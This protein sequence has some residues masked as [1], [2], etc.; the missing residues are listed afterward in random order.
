MSN[1]GLLAEAPRQPH[2]LAP[3]GWLALVAVVAAQVIGFLISRPDRVMGN[4][5]KIMYVHVP[6]AWVAMI[7]FFLV[8]VASMLYLWRRDLKYDRL[9]ASAT[10]VSVLFTGLTLALG[11]IWGRPTWGIWWTWDPRLTSTAIMLLIY[12]GY[13]ALR[14]FTEDEERRARWSAAVGILGFLNVPIVYFSV[15]WWRTLHQV[16]TVDV[17]GTIG[18]S[19]A[20]S[21]IINSLAFMILFAWLVG[22]RTHVAGLERQREAWLEEQAL[23]GSEAN[24]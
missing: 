14:S 3:T 15:K 21:L 11:S 18:S 10:E 9:A 13:L 23:T 22:L 16:Q 8:F 2:W 7:G 6:S 5:Q 19:Y 12:V 1:G 4:L 20:I 17:T 24:V